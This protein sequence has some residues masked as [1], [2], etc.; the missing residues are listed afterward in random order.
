MRSIKIWNDSA[1]DRQL[2]EIAEGLEEGMT[3]VLPTDSRYAFA[4]DAL[5]K[6]AVENVCRLKGLNPKKSNLSV[7]CADI[8]MAAEYARIDNRLFRL[9]KENTPGPFTFICPSGNSLPRILRDRREI[10][11][12]IPAC[13]V[14]R[15]IAGRLGHPL[16]VTSIDSDDEDYL[17]NPE[18]IM[19]ISEG[20]ADL[21]IEGE[22]GSVGLTTVV[23]CTGYETEI[24]RQGIG[25][26]V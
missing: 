19:D 9:L 20:K 10:G 7:L 14:A 2:S 25:E 16:L 23:D 1:S 5:Q 11:I 8:S 22:E 18:L 6:K 12:R 13:E 3:V 24:V 26:L 4:C 21:F 17:V 15:Q